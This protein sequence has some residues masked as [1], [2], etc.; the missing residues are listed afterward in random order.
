MMANQLNVSIE[1]LKNEAEK[2]KESAAN[3]NTQAE[4][5][6]GIMNDLK[7]IWT[8]DAAKA[9][10]DKYDKLRSDVTKLTSLAT[11]FSNDLT[12]ITKNYEETEK[13]NQ[14]KTAS[15]LQDVIS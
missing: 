4:N 7:T 9:Y 15:L 1:K 8:G 3:I 14:E 11:N 2:F 5:I 10:N 6:T 13:S 12:A